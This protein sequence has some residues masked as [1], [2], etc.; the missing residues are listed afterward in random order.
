M[1]PVSA[2]EGLPGQPSQQAPVFKVGTVTV[3]FVGT[4]NVNEQVVRANMQV[5]EG[6]DLDQSMLDRDIKSLYR[7]GLFEFINVNQEAVDANTF[8]LVIEVTPK[9]RVF[10]VRFEGNKKVRTSR[11][12]KEAKTKPNFALDE[13]QVKDDTEKLREYYQKSGYNQV[14][15][16]YV[17]ERDRVGGFGTVVFKIKEGEKVKIRDVRFTGNAH[18]KKARLKKEMETKRWWMFSWLTGSGRFKDEQFED[19]LDKLR[20]YYR[21]QG[22]LDVEIPQAIVGRIGQRAA[23]LKARQG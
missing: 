14:S 8:N 9:F 18:V 15:V 5:R 1:A 6:G 17:V 4:A 13:R 10:A 20:D 12:E 21:E 22:Y 19:D 3:K 16:T 23:P 7:T 11:L 2:Q